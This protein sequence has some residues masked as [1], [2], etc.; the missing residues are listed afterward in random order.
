MGKP[1][2]PG[3][4]VFY[5]AMALL[6]LVLV[7]VLG[8]TDTTRKGIPLWLLAAVGVPLF[9]GLAVHSWRTPRRSRDT[10]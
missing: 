8:P 5:V 1:A 3:G 9:L 10:P 6:M 4:V 7:L 2:N